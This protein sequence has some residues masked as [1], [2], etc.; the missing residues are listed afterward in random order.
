M[1]GSYKAKVKSSRKRITKPPQSKPL[2]RQFNCD[3]VSVNYFRESMLLLLTAL[4]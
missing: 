3:L 4:I 2:S 1:G